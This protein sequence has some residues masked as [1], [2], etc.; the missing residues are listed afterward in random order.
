MAIGAEF[1]ERVAQEH[2]VGGADRGRQFELAFAN[3]HR[4]F[5]E[6]PSGA[7]ESRCIFVDNEDYLLN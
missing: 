3:G 1:W 2:G 7:L 4:V 6:R 5:H